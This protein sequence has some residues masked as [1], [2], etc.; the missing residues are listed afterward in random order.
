[1][2]F[3][4]FFLEPMTNKA[5]LVLLAMW[6]AFLSPPLEFILLDVCHWRQHF[7]TL[8]LFEPDCLK[9]SACEHHLCFAARHMEAS[10]NPDCTIYSL[11]IRR[12][13]WNYLS[14]HISCPNLDVTWSLSK[15][16]SRKYQLCPWKILSSLLTELGVSF[17]SFPLSPSAFPHQKEEGEDVCFSLSLL[18]PLFFTL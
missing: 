1:M 12:G 16:H 18:I 13:P 9:T 6:S 3:F 11:E 15:P 4:G 17:T 5:G 14:S 7:C 2:G 8:W 10:I